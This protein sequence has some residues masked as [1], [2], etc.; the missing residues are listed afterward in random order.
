[1]TNLT[2]RQEKFAQAIMQGKTQRQAYYEAY[3]KSKKWKPEVVDSKASTM[4][5][6]EKVSE[7]LNFLRNETAIENKITRN[8]LI[9]QLRVIGFANINIDDIKP[10]DKI[11]AI[12]VMAELM[13]YDK[14]DT[15][16][17]ITI[18]PES[19]LTTEELKTL[20]KNNP[21]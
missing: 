3:E 6:N 1:M 12:A 11:K 18:T 21:L 2:E 7:R 16:I 10:N 13:G 20:A 19:T 8:D 9:D 17:N 14:P 4:M 15:E 5:K